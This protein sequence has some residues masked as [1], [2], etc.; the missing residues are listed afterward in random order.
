VDKT[1][2]RKP[3]YWALFIAVAI[4]VAIFITATISPIRDSDGV[5]VSPLLEQ[6][7]LDT[8]FYQESRHQYAALDFDQATQKMK[9]F[10]KNPIKDHGYILALPVFPLILEIFHYDQGSTI[11]LALF[12]L[13]ISIALCWLWLYWLNDQQ[14]PAWA[15]WLFAVLLNPIWFMLAV[16]TD[17][18]FSLIFAVFFIFYFKKSSEKRIL[19]WFIPLLVLLL[20]RPNGITILLFVIWDK[21]FN[22]ENYRHR[23]RVNIIAFIVLVPVSIFLIPYFWTFI[24][25]SSSF[26]FFSIA[27]KEYLT[28]LFSWL[29]A[30]VNQLASWI[31]FAGAK[32]L[33]FVGLRPSYGNIS[34]AWVLLRSFAGIILLPGIIYLFLKGDQRHKMLFLFYFFPV[35]LGASQDRYNLPLQP[36][37]YYYG[38]L[39]IIALKNKLFS[40]ES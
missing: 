15:L 40:R 3:L 18:F 34:L 2:I 28:G 30:G 12:Y 38:V 10:Y 24:K 22:N 19:S 17:L 26:T 21:L 13:C 29:P 36:I 4:R 27:S 7:T 31:C 5:L 23:T 8:S 1:M 32:I 25:A 6:V 35:F 16:S 9:E 33:Y 14:I 20:T 39:C 37:L 11:P